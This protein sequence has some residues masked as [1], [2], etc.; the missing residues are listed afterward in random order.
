MFTVEQE[1]DLSKLWELR[2]ANLRVLEGIRD[3]GE[4]VT[5]VL[6]QAAIS[7]SAAAGRRAPR[8]TGT[9]QSAH[10]GEYV[11][12]YSRVFIDPSVQNPV[13]GG[14]PALYGPIVHDDRRPWFDET[15]AADA[16]GILTHAGEML[17]GRLGGI[18]SG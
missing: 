10:R 2:A 4:L 17:F 7:L 15:I 1:A 9:L 18:W 6:T 16:P 11:N 8:L 3:G 12:P 5:E 14:Y 13:L